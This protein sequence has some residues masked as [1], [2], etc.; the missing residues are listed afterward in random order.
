MPTPES[1]YVAHPDVVSQA[2]RILAATVGALFTALIAVLLYIWHS[3]TKK[4][5]DIS[6]TMQRKFESISIEFKNDI[7]GMARSL[8]NISNTLFDRQREVE[9]RIGRQ[10]TRC[11]ERHGKFP[12]GTI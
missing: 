3:H 1:I 4:I 10:E 9:D 7:S 12:G 5:D 6:A 8:E 2:I 11:E